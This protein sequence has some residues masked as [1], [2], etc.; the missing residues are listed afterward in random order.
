VQTRGEFGG[1]GIEVSMENGLVKV[2]SPIDDTPAARAGLKPGDL[3][4]HLNGDAV[5]GLSLQ[6]AVEKMINYLRDVTYG[7]DYVLGMKIQKGLEA[8]AFD[9]IIFGKNERGNQFFHETVEWYLKNDPNA[10]KPTL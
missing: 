5:Q 2:V 10:P 9:S 6:E 4:T 7:D 3:I 8:R 1:L